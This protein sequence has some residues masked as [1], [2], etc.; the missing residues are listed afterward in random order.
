M[1]LGDKPI[2]FLEGDLMIERRSKA[3]IQVAYPAIVR[4]KDPVHGKFQNKAILDNLSANGLHLHLDRIV[5]ND[6]RLLVSF[7]ISKMDDVPHSSRIVARGRVVRVEP[8]S[9]STCGLAI[10]LERHRF[11]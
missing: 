10:K 4:G 2:G 6:S 9:N 1:L 5:E 3:R 7:Q 8:E 11:I